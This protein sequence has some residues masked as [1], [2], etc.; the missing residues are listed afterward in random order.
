VGRRDRALISTKA[1]LPAGDGPADSGTCRHRLIG[2]SNFV[3][4]QLMKS[5]ATADAGPP[6]HEQ[7]MF[8]VLD[9]LSVI[10]HEPTYPHFP[11]VRAIRFRTAESAAVRRTRGALRA[12]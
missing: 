11:Y 7:I 10:A 5:P 12:A 1:A 9:E 2:V 8:D 4:W 6:V 3:G